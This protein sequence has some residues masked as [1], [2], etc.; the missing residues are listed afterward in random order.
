MILD[1]ILQNSGDKRPYEAGRL[2]YFYNFFIE[3]SRF[4]TSLIKKN[5]SSVYC[6]PSFKLINQ[7]PETKI[8]GHP[9]SRRM[10]GLV[11]MASRDKREIKH[12]V[13]SN[14]KRQK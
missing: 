1:R 10:R 7:F 14:G 13:T 5:K 12:D 4:F 3:I 8:L 11:Y 2:D 6:S 9:V